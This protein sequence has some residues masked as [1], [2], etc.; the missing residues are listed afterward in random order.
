MTPAQKAAWVAA[1]RSGRYTQGKE[2][3]RDRD[4]RFCCLGV[5]CDLVNPDGWTEPNEDDQ[6]YGF[7]LYE[8]A[9]MPPIELFGWEDDGVMNYWPK[10]TI[11]GVSLSFD[12]HNDDEGRTFAEIADAIEAQL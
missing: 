9:Q 3:L 11:G 6:A 10:V 8:N 12:V 2:Y 7:G 4:N 5:Y 1:L